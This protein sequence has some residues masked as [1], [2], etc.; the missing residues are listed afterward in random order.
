MVQDYIWG[1]KTLLYLQARED[2]KAQ[3]WSGQSPPKAY[4]LRYAGRARGSL[5]RGLTVRNIIGK[6]LPKFG[7][8]AEERLKKRETHLAT[9]D[10]LNPPE[11]KPVCLILR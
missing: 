5:V 3:G 8:F 7:P 11:K 1:L 6:G 9:A 10:L 2:L 4:D